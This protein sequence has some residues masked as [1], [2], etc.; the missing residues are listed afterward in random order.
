MSRNIASWKIIIPMVLYSAGMIF[1]SVLPRVGVIVISLLVYLYIL[2][3]LKK[4]NNNID[5]L[6]LLSII[7]IPTSTISIIGTNYGDLPLTWF[8]IIVLILV[9]LIGIKG[10]L[11]AKYFVSI[12]LFGIFELMHSLFMPSLGNSLKQ[13]LTIMLLL[14]AFLI[15]SYVR[16]YS[17]NDLTEKMSIYY[18]CGTVSVAVQV[19][20]QRF[21]IM[22]TG[23][24]IGHYA[25]MGSGRFAYA[26][27]FGDYSFASLYIATGAL[28]IFLQYVNKRKI[29]L[30]RFVLV[31][32]IMLSATLMVSARTGIFA[33]AIVG[34]LYVILNFNKLNPRLVLVIIG[35]C[36][37]APSLAGRLLSIRGGQDLLDSSGRVEMYME[38]LKFF[39]DKP[40]LGY[41]LGLENLNKLTGLGAIHNFIIQYL[42]QMGIIGTILFLI[43]FYIFIKQTRR[44]PG[45]Y[46]W[47]F[48]LVMI[49]AMFIPD[50]VSSRFL[51]AV[52]LLC[53][54]RNLKSTYKCGGLYE[55]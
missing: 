35:I 7:A 18:L 50:I 36:I 53:M 26:G 34:L 27:L 30:I 32:G 15:G 28:L 22:A 37:V 3:M 41:G 8:N 29:S 1:Y 54:C 42:V 45:I 46:M 25:A 20:L 17:Y 47:L 13:L 2:K 24:V 31:E 4:D 21:Y 14:F 33:L 43:P 39:A 44:N 49:G 52:I 11:N 40:M 51:Y 23:H 6:I 19:F 12:M 10:K 9:M 5:S 16:N 48:W 55:A 38:A